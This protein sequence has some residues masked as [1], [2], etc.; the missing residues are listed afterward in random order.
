MLLSF[1][2]Y[3]NG[4]EHLGS[5]PVC[6]WQVLSAHIDSAVNTFKYLNTMGRC[7]HIIWDPIEGTTIF[8]LPFDKAG[9]LFSKE[10]N[11]AGLPLIQVAVLGTREMP[12]T[13]SPLKG[14]VEVFKH[15]KDHGVPSLW[16][17]GPPSLYG[18]SRALQGYLEAGHYSIDQIDSA[19]PGTG[20]IDVRKLSYE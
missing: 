8:P 20:P 1:P 6:V 18:H 15:L 9:C 16:P 19:F 4:G 17:K 5:N 7:P 11:Q 13:D 3:R 10:V 14:A 2:A 12:F